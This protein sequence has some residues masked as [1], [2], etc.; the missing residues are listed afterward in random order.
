MADAS[1]LREL[2]LALDG[3]TSAPHFDRTAFKVKRIF[4]TLAADGLTANFKLTPDEQALKCEVMPDAFSPVPNAWGQQGWTVGTLAKLKTIELAAA[5]E[6]A[7][8]H[9][10]PA[11]RKQKP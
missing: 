6:M 5:L 11:P 7:W 2:A 8:Q 3:V 10:L 4:V 1:S 9:A